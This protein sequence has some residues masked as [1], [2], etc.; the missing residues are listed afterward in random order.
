MCSIL[1]LVIYLILHYIRLCSK[2]SCC[3]SK[4]F[5]TIQ[6]MCILFDWRKTISMSALW[7]LSS[8]CCMQ[9]ITTR[10]SSMS[11]RNRQICSRFCLNVQWCK[12]VLN[13]W[14]SNSIFRLIILNKA[15]HL[16]YC[17][18]LYSYNKLLI[19]LK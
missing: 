13:I 9:S 14:I 3:A 19:F 2:T 10:M 11:T 17:I 5:N 18:V 12:L 15:I 1:L 6:S 8:M 16:V 7:T 4:Q